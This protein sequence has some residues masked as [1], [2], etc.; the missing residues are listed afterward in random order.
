M[1]AATQLQLLDELCELESTR[2]A[3][4]LS[5]FEHARWL[6]LQKLLTRELC[7]FSTGSGEERRSTLRV[8]CPLDVKVQSADA[9]FVGTAIDVSAGGIGVRAQLLPAAGEHVRLLWAEEPKGQHF[10]LDLP[11]HVVWLR[12][13]PHALGAGFGV[14][15]DPRDR[16]Q[17]QALS[18]LLLFLLRRERKRLELPALK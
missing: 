18:Q 13:I 15:F 17:E 14:A 7:D 8:P 16:A 9:A 10:E 4:I 1:S 2:Q 11:G 3:R 5:K 6:E 12:K